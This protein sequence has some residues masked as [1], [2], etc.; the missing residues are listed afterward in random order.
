MGAVGVFLRRGL[1]VA[2]VGNADV[3]TGA[4]ATPGA[5]VQGQVG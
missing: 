3:V 2:P 4:G 5:V 1:A